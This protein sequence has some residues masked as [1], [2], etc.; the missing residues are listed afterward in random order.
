MSHLSLETLARLVDEAPDATEAA[1]LEACA[2]CRVEL[3]AMREDVHALG[4][5]PDMTPAPDGWAALER[6]LGAEGL[7]QTR[8]PAAAASSWPRIMQMAAALVLFLAGSLAGRMTA[9]PAP[10]M[11]A[12]DA[13]SAPTVT[14]ANRADAG[15]VRL[16]AS[17]DTRHVAGPVDAPAAA[18]RVAAVDRPQ[19]NQPS[20]VRLASSGG[21]FQA[22]SPETIDEAAA[23]LRETEAMYLT[24]L[25]RY[26]E[27][28]TRS[29]V[30]DPV[31]RLAA[32]QSI[33]MTTQAALSQAPADPV[34]N[35]VHLAT[36]AQRDATLAQVA[37]ATGERWY[38]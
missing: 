14:G 35:G 30:G 10:S 32:L 15:D 8:R 33:V 21:G 19:P 18:P 34:I 36:L 25:T 6:R 1:H 37:A 7:I 31:A 20:S 4:M 24:A 29:D 9:A 27:F 16:D 11:T 17:P 22:S 38:E 5:L 3:D 12:F 2:A 23:L 28:A 13:T 26:A